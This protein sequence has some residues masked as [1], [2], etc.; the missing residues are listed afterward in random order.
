MLS[1]PLLK[2]SNISAR[3]FKSLRDVSIQLASPLAVFVGRNNTGKSSILDIFEFIKQAAVDGNAAVQARGSSALNLVWGNA[4]DGR[5]QITL[6]FDVP[7]E[8][9]GPAI[10]ALAKKHPTDPNGT[11]DV[12]RLKREDVANS[13]FLKRLKYRLTF[14]DGFDEAIFTTDPVNKAHQYPLASRSGTKELFVSYW[15]SRNALWNHD[16]S[17]ITGLPANQTGQVYDAA[18]IPNLL[19]SDYGVKTDSEFA[20]PWLQ[21]FFQNVYHSYP[22]RRPDTL[23]DI[24]STPLIDTDGRNLAD[25]LNY[26]RNN[27]ESV[28]RRIE[29]DVSEIVDGIKT[30]STPTFG[31][32]TT[33]RI[34]EVLQGDRNASFD[35]KQMSSGTAQLLVLL[36]QLHTRPQNS[37]VLL[38]E[39]EGMLHPH[40]QAEFFR[41]LRLLSNEVTI[42]VSTHSAVIASEARIDSLFLIKKD[43]GE[44]SIQCYKEGVADEIIEEM[45]LRPSYNFEANTVVFVEGVFDLAVFKAW[46]DEL[47]ICRDVSLLDSGGYSKIQFG[48]NA[49]ILRS[50]A[51]RTRVFAVV[52]GDT[53]EKGDYS[54]IK[55]A[56]KIPESDILELE[57]ENLE[58]L[59]ASPA[60]ITAAFPKVHVEEKAFDVP[61]SELKA[62]LNLV[63]RSVGGYSE[64]NAVKLA[65]QV[66]PPERWKEFF[67]RVDIFDKR[68]TAKSV[69]QER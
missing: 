22:I 8:L 12:T 47:K 32:T 55:N 16:G 14:G 56:L 52:D 2:L 9:R 61:A 35:L 43:Q 10:Q 29:N 65:A 33:T 38:E 54:A 26:L 17:K 66:S 60:A 4:T 6:D 42:L 7:A 48:T 5:A 21:D 68:V 40:A 69:T 46:L 19:F 57:Q 23:R 30:L 28:F 49:K 63:L 59:L 45:G 41:I 3:N 20:F 37:L 24:K 44:S 39:I 11:G 53:R 1:K 27:E 36:T 15:D 34:N 25:V 67:S 64:D 58:C 18:T 13:G 31:A 51:V 50:K 62:A